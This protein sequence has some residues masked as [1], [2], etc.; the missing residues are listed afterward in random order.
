MCKSQLLENQ[1]CGRWGGLSL[2]KT[3]TKNKKK[4]RLQMTAAFPC[5]TGWKETAA[6][7]TL[8]VRIGFV[9]DPTGQF[10][11]VIIWPAGAN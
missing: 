8:V 5:E 1:L 10:L 6:V 9:Y 3:T 2:K 11:Q 4:R 7:R